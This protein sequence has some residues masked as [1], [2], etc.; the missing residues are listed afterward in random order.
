MTSSELTHLRQENEQIKKLNSVLRQ[1]NEYFRQKLKDLGHNVASASQLEE[2]RDFSESVC[3]PYPSVKKFPPKE[4]ID[5]TTDV[6]DIAPNTK[7]RSWV[8]GKIVYDFEQAHDFDPPKPHPKLQAA[9]GKSHIPIKPKRKIV[10]RASL[11]HSGKPKPPV[12]KQS[13]KPPMP[14]PPVPKPP[15][16]KQKSVMK[17]A[18]PP[19]PHDAKKSTSPYIPKEVKK[20]APPKPK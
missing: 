5:Q 10:A 1:E 20:A 19:I 7:R 18:A 14:K 2:D 9:A 16:K 3:P 17:K 13:R 4:S 15:I 11:D 6:N 12:S 8:D